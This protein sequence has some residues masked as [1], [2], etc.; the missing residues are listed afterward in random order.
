MLVRKRWLRVREVSW[1]KWPVLGIRERVA[2]T[3][4]VQEHFVN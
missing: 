2:A 4:L 3:S 1:I